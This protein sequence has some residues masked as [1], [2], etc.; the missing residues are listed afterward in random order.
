MK[1]S[2]GSASFVSTK[3]PATESGRRSVRSWQRTSASTTSRHSL[4]TQRDTARVRGGSRASTSASTSRG[5]WSLDLFPRRSR[6]PALEKGRV[7]E[8][9]NR[10]I[11]ARR[12]E[13]TRVNQTRLR[14]RRLAW[15]VDC[16]F[17]IYWWNRGW[18]S[19]SV[20]TLGMRMKNGNSFPNYS[21]PSF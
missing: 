10:M 13:R 2:G 17:Y 20:T 4:Q 15:V 9:L 1:K 19:C 7:R 6:E 12:D 5:T 3:M 8:N 21:I 16:F 11:E 14:P 18:T